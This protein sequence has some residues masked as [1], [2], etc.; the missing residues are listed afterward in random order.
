MISHWSAVLFFHLV[1]TPGKICPVVISSFQN[2]QRKNKRKHHFRKWKLWHKHKLRGQVAP[3]HLLPVL[4]R[5]IQTDLSI[6]YCCTQKREKDNASALNVQPRD[7][8]ISCTSVFRILRIPCRCDPE[9][10]ALSK[11][12]LQGQL[13]LQSYKNS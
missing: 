4:L 7:C 6:V 9:A 12:Q 3:L 2:Q 10:Y 1:K 11:H 5:A 8:T 13:R